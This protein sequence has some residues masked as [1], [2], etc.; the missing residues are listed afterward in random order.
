MGL[1]RAANNHAEAFPDTIFCNVSNNEKITF[2]FTSLSYMI[3]VKSKK[4]DQDICLKIE[5]HNAKL[6]ALTCIGIIWKNSL[7]QTAGPHLIQVLG[8][9]QEFV[10]LTGF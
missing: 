9:T 6:Q 8:G 3:Y 2:Y 7:K 10:F 5:M 4:K 1:C